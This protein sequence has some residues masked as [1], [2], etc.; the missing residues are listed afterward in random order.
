MDNLL[1]EIRLFAGA[2]IPAD[3]ALCNG[4]T[5]A[6]ADF[7]GLHNLIGTTYG[8]D[9]VTTF[10]LPDLRG[11]VPIGMGNGPG[12]TNRVLGDHGGSGQVT[13]TDNQIGHHSHALLARPAADTP[14]PS[15]HF[16]AATP[17]TILPYNDASVASGSVA[18]FT[19]TSITPNAPAR[20]PRDNHMPSAGIGYIIALTGI[21]PAN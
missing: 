19:P 4:A 8:G 2:R 12:L 14:D 5:L 16:L 13:L 17:P 9:G 11:R 21:W 3:W 18:S 1:G 20:L 15:D 6:I 10:A 7:P